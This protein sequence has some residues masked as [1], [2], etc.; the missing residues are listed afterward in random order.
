MSKS[1]YDLEKAQMGDDLLHVVVVELESLEIGSHLVLFG[2]DDLPLG[3]LEHPEF[4]LL[5]FL[6]LAPNFDFGVILV[7]R[8]LQLHLLV[9]LVVSQVFGNLHIFIEVVDHLGSLAD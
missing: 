8:P 1:L 4:V 7:V 5:L 3:N 9:R 6:D 2:L